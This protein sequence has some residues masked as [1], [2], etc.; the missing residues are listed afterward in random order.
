MSLLTGFVSWSLISLILAEIPIRFDCKV[1][2]KLFRGQAATAP[3]VLNTICHMIC[4]FPLNLCGI[5]NFE[6]DSLLFVP[7]QECNKMLAESE[8]DPKTSISK[9]SMQ[10]T[11]G[12]A[13]IPC[14]A[15]ELR[16]YK[17]CDD[18]SRI[19]KLWTKHCRAT[20][21]LM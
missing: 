14:F 18:C 4:F 9:R 11:R 10:L 12:V 21:L 16:G 1:P 6:L 19:V 8:S 13:N 20:R 17:L 5:P 15:Y 3:L 2:Q 7:S